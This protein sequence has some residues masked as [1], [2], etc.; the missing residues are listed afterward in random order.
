[1]VCGLYLTIL[2]C[3]QT[4]LVH[5]IPHCVDLGVSAAKAAA[6]AAT[7]GGVSMLGRL[8]M[9]FAGDRI[10]NKRAMAACF[11]I[12][13][14]ALSWL[15]LAKELWMLYLFAAVYGF[16]HGG[17]FALIS[18]VVAGLFGTRSQGILLG[19]VICS[20]T[21]G[22]AIGPFL[23]GAIFDTTGSY[24][25]AFLVLLTLAIIGLV[26]TMLLKPRAKSDQGG[27]PLHAEALLT[28]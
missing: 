28:S 20:G 4:V 3:T 24:R 25:L 7:I 26:L 15:Q 10:G 14:A 8:T 17:F 18:P 5:I 21:F 27:A 22:G 19:I 16:S 13:V 11:L 23:T 1:M 2:F 6:V 9:G 12:L